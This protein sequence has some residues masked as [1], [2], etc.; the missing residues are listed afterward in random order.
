MSPTINELKF[1]NIT[2]AR[3]ELAGSVLPGAT[4]PIKTYTFYFNNSKQTKII[5]DVIKYLISAKAQENEVTISINSNKNLI[6][7]ISPEIRKLIDG[8][9]KDIF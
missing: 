9:Y 7:I 2:S 4:S 5:E 3:I 1:E 8:G 6:R